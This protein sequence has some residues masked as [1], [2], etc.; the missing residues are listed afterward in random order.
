MADA[1]DYPE[2]QQALTPY[3]I[4]KGA[5]EAIRFY[6]EAFGATELF[7]LAGPDGRIGHAEVRIV[8]SVLMLADEAPDFG[9]MSPPSVGGSP[10]NLHLYVDDVDQCVERAVAAG[11]TVLRSVKDEFYGDRTGMI[12][13]PFGHRWHLA[14]HKRDVSAEEMQDRWNTVS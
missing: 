8:D 10:V 7:R 5:G 4:V 13:D 11:A 14:T 9:A 6:T 2:R 1:T 12:L 3:L